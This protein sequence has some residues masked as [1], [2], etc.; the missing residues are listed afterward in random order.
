MSTAAC[1]EAKRSHSTGPTL[2]LT[3]SCY[4]YVALAQVDGE[5]V[6]TDSEVTPGSAALPH[7]RAG[8]SHVRTRQWAERLMAGSMWQPTPYVFTTEWA[9]HPRPMLSERCPQGRIQALVFAPASPRL[10][11][12]CTLCWHRLPCSLGCC[13][14][15]C[16]SGVSEIS[17][18]SRQRRDHPSTSTGRSAFLRPHL[19]K[20]DSAE[21]S[22]QGPSDETGGDPYIQSRRRSSRS[23]IGTNPPR[24]CAGRFVA[25]ASSCWRARR[26]AGS[27]WRTTNP[28]DRTS[29][30]T[31][32][33]ACLLA[34]RA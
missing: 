19:P 23:I 22:A 14:L 3:P 32:A 11:W 7:C 17:L 15:A 25:R 30:L 18:R 12:G 21:G 20:T 6:V 9:T 33:F 16:R 2:I 29:A 27:A 10:I 8:L 4:G 28:G 5:L 31:G 13:P 1:G 26:R 24:P 34:M